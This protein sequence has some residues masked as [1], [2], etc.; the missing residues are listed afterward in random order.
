MRCLGH[1]LLIAMLVGVSAC[2]DQSDS[3]VESRQEVEVRPEVVARPQGEVRR[4]IVHVAGDIYLFHNK[5][6]VSVLMVT[7]EGVIATD[8]I[9][10]EAAAWLNEEIKR[11]FGQPI[12]YV[13]YSHDHFDHVAG[14]AAF[15]DATFIAHANAPKHI[16]ISEHPIVM[17]DIVFNEGLILELGGK[18]VELFYFGVSHSDNLIFMRFPEDRVLFVVDIL[19]MRMLPFRDFG[20]TDIDGMLMGL[21]ALEELDFDIIVAGHSMGPDHNPVGTRDDLIEYREYIETL[22]QRV[23]SELAADKSVEEIKAAVTMPEY[24]HFLGYEEIAGFPAWQPLNVVGMVR[25]LREQE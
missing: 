17:P 7:D 3:Q 4:E 8:P 14:G 18:Q 16:A 1:C 2:S 12:K 25:Y 11:Q 6:H 13:I 24:R 22:K 23:A 15:E 10:A 20:S 21:R 5:F 9:N 19:E